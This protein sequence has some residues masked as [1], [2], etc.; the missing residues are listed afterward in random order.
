MATCNKDKIIPPYG[1]IKMLQ[2]KIPPING[3]PPSMNIHSCLN[4]HPGRSLIR[5]SNLQKHYNVKNNFMHSRGVKEAE[6]SINNNK[7]EE[8]W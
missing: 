8:T 3:R 7:Y 4:V 6:K 1:L 2:I 5:E